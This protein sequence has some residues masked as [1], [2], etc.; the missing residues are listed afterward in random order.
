MSTSS[1]NDTTELKALVVQAVASAKDLLAYLDKHPG[2]LT[3]LKA[4]FKSRMGAAI[5]PRLIKLI[6]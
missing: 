4:E 5:L 3:E 6:F 1:D 2:K